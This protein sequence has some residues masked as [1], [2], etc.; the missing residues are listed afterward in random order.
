[1]MTGV[2]QWQPGDPTPHE[3]AIDSTELGC[4]LIS[5]GSSWRAV[6]VIQSRRE[7][8][9]QQ[10]CW[11]TSDIVR[12]PTC[13]LQARQRCRVQAGGSGSKRWGSGR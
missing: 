2:G 11:T 9:R 1:M 7:P 12:S 13:K 4:H 5:R 3:T 10:A 8:Q 6:G